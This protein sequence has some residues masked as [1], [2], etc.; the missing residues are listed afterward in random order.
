MGLALLPFFLL[1][2]STIEAQSLFDVTRYGAKPNTDITQALANAWKE[3]CMSTTPSKLLIPKGVYQLSQSYLKGPC[4]SVPIQVQVD[5]TLKAPLHPNGDGLVLFAYIDQLMLSGTGVFDGQGKAGWD[6]NDCHKKKI[7]TKLPMNLKFSF[8]TNSIV[9]DITSL[10][11]KNFHINLLGCK[12][13]TFQHVTISAPENSPNT[14]GIHISSSEQINILDSK[15][16]TGDDCVSVGDSNK[17]VTITNVTCGP[18]HG[19]SVGSLGKY[20]KEKDVV[21]VTVKAC[22]LINTTNGV[23]IKTWPDSA[24]AFIASDMH[25]EDI[26]MQNVS[27]PVI[28]DQEYCP[29][30]QCNRKVPSKIKISKVSFKNIR[31]TSATPI[32]VKLVCSKSIPCEGVEVADINLTYSGIR[33]PILSECANVQPLITGKQSPQICAK[34]APAGA[35]STD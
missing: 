22:K 14:D 28:I 15:I 1:L 12:N 34:P 7:C 9:K 23:R 6:K 17:Q 16:S 33:G 3:A 13:V 5:G 25:F 2:A 11:S 31:G 32:A 4:K 24:G 18:G 8:I 20:T 30:N 26:E 27:N 10:D 21:G 35:P 19:I 29:W